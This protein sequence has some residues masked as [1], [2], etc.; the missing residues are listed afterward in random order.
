MI[1]DRD[2]LKGILLPNI[3]ISMTTNNGSVHVA[4]TLPDYT[5]NFASELLTDFLGHLVTHKV[6]KDFTVT[7]M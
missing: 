4:Y 3:I 7:K 6:I 1:T 5:Q 2:Y